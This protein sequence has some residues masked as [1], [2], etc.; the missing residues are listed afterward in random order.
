MNFRIGLF[1][2][3][4]GFVLFLAFANRISNTFGGLHFDLG[5][6]ESTMIGLLIG[7]VFCS[8]LTSDGLALRELSKYMIAVSGP[9]VIVLM[10]ASISKEEVVSIFYYGTAFLLYLSI[11]LVI[12]PKSKS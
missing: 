5:E 11:P 10:L 3:I 7:T 6:A 4:W 2:V 9:V 12:I 1:R 8:F